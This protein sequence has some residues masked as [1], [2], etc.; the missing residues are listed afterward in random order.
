MLNQKMIESNPGC[1]VEE[2]VS[3]ENK[4][5]LFGSGRVILGNPVMGKVRVGKR[6]K[7]F[8]TQV[9]PHFCPFCGKSLDEGGE[10]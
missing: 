3:F 2:S 9:A 7:K 6:I 4:T 8:T 5:I 1:E 10:A